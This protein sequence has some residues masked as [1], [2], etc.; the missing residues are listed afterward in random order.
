M[1]K[2]GSRPTTRIEFTN[3][4]H[5]TSVRVLVPSDLIDPATDAVH[6]MRTAWEWL[7][8]QAG[9]KWSGPGAGGRHP[10]DGYRH[11][12]S[13]VRQALCGIADCRCGTVL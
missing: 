2:K 4:F 3:S 10:S 7:Q 9:T 12:L 11:T 6:R 8:H 5:G 13:R 1:T